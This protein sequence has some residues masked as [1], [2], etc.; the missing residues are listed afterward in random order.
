MKDILGR[1]IKVDDLV[2]AKGTGRYSRGLNV[3]IWNGKSVRFKSSNASYS[4]LFL[5]ENPSE[6]ELKYK[7]EILNQI[8]KEKQAAKEREAKRKTMKRILKKELIIGQE[9]RDDKGSRY[10]YL[11]QG[12]YE[13]EGRW[14]NENGEGVLLTYTYY[15]NKE[16]SQ[17]NYELFE[18]IFTRKTLPRFVSKTNRK[19]E[20]NKNIN[21][22]KEFGS[23]YSKS[24]TTIK[25]NLD[26]VE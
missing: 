21:V 2:V 7:Q 22:K 4:E 16:Y 10:F 18:R 23:G 19:V 24:F 26:E 3:G 25:I 5:I 20:L 12:S 8:E 11:G 6:N 1:E 9:Y 17:S 14:R 15:E 13:I